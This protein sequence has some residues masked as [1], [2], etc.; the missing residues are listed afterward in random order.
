MNIKT[1]IFQRA[2][3]YEYSWKEKVIG[4]LGYPLLFLFILWLGPAVFEM[5][6]EARR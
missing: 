5:L 6:R 2:A 4:I 3:R 1:T